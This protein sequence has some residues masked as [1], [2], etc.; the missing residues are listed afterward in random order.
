M[1]STRNNE[2]PSKISVLAFHCRETRSLRTFYLLNHV[3]RNVCLS[4]CP[5]VCNKGSLSLRNF[6]SQCTWLAHEALFPTVAR[7][8]LH[9]TAVAWLTGEGDAAA[10]VVHLR[11]TLSGWPETTDDD[12]ALSLVSQLA[13]EEQGSSLGWLEGDACWE[14]AVL[15]TPA[16]GRVLIMAGPGLDRTEQRGHWRCLAS[17]WPSLPR[18]GLGQALRL[19]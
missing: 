10:A 2:L 19:A 7:W 12:A 6:C 15:H 16:L 13:S 5:M 9:L 3:S 4:K 14:F 8:L 11:R 1:P 18:L 17:V